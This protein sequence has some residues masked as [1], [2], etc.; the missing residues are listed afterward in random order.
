MDNEAG[1]EGI[2]RLEMVITKVSVENATVEIY[3]FLKTVFFQFYEKKPYCFV[4]WRMME[5]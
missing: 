1:V 4:Q 3:Q 2:V 5:S